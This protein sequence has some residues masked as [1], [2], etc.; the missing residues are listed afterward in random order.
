MRKAAAL[1][2]VLLLATFSCAQTTPSSPETGSPQAPPPNGAT[3]TAGTEIKATLDTPLSSKTSKPGDRFTATVQQPVPAANGGTAIPSASH[4]NGEVTQAEAGR[5]QPQ[6]RGKGQLNL[7]FREVVL[8]NGTAIPVTATL[9]SIRDT[10]AAG[11]GSPN[12]EGQVRSGNAGKGVARDLGVGA[13]AGGGYVVAAKEKDVN[14]PANSGIV[15]RLDQPI[16][17]PASATPGR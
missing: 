15:L 9:V 16:I 11:P 2:F 12:E 13:A 4:I 17:I 3:V 5:T 7:R 10:H 6:L 1:L 14:L 8:P